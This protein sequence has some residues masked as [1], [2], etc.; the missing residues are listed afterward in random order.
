MDVGGVEAHGPLRAAVG[1]NPLWEIPEVEGLKSD[2]P[3]CA[4][5]LSGGASIACALL[6]GATAKAVVFFF[7]MGFFLFMYI[8]IQN[9]ETNLLI[10]NDIIPQQV[11][12]ANLI[13]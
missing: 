4:I 12:L 2:F 5:T 1:G 7:A 3:V 8:L 9:T 6:L 10:A 11:N 13:G